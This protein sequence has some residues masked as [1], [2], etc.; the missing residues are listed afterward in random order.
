MPDTPLTDQQLEAYTALAA[1]AADDPLYVSDCEGSLQVWRES[2][3]TH[4]RRDATGAIEMYSFPSSYR[5]TDQVI[6][7]DLDTWDPGEDASDDQRRQDICDLVDSR[8]A[9]GA[10]VAEVNRLRA[11]VTELERPAVEAKR[12]E[13]RASYA[14]LINACEET[15]DFEGAFDV[16]CRLREREDQ[17]KTEDAAAV[18]AAVETGE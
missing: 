2:A 6:E 15:K 5:V 16:Q 11:R 13:I 14:E 3:L 4:V 8:A 12:N 17:W 18:P 10:L 9:V 1:R 7:I